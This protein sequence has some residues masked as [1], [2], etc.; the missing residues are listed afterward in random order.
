MLHPLLRC[1]R[2]RHLV[3]DALLNPLWRR[4]HSGLWWRDHAIGGFSL[5]WSR[6][7]GCALLRHH[8]LL[9]DDALWRWSR[10]W[11]RHSLLGHTVLISLVRRKTL[12]RWSRRERHYVHRHALLRSYSLSGWLPLRH[13]LKGHAL[14]GHA[15]LLEDDLLGTWE[16]LLRE[17]LLRPALALHGYKAMWRLALLLLMLLRHHHH[18]LLLQGHAG[19]RGQHLRLEWLSRL[20]AR[21]RHWKVYHIRRQLSWRGHG[22]RLSRRP[23][24]HL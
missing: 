24:H 7:L 15:W 14:R 23:W 8:A 5:Q 17:A 18:R 11:G 9:V 19:L 3:V 6:L 22:H 21:G 1:S 2:C 16:A 13:A 12:W 10:T 4:S 20:G